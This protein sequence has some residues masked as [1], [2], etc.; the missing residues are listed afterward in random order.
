VT[1]NGVIEAELLKDALST[2]PWWWF[3]NNV[4]WWQWLG[5]LTFKLSYIK[6]SDEWCM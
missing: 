4:C 2:R 3:W 5:T 1:L 6:C